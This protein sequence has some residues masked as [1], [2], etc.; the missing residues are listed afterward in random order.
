MDVSLL[1]ARRTPKQHIHQGLMSNEEARY[2]ET[3]ENE[4]SPGAPQFDDR[5]TTQR[6]WKNAAGKRHDNC[7]NSF[8]KP[9]RPITLR[10]AQHSPD[11]ML[12]TNKTE[13]HLWHPCHII[14]N[15]HREHIVDCGDSLHVVGRKSLQ[16]T[17][18]KV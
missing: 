4:R 16:Q 18:R 10:K 1:E 8:R 2:P 11:Q 3:S 12:L 5:D 6:A 15:H 7:T 13:G 17:K 14:R 9:K